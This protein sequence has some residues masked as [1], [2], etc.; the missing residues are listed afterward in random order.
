[1][2]VISK[3]KIDKR[4]ADNKT[5]FQEDRSSRQ[6]VLCCSWSKSNGGKKS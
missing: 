6:H 2:E 1:L 3:S 4:I 5:G